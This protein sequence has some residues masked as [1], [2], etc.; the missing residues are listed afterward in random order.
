MDQRYKG[1]KNST[2]KDLLE[3][4]GQPAANKTKAALRAEL[5]EFLIGIGVHL[6]SSG[7]L[8][9]LRKRGTSYIE[10]PQIHPVARF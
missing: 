1:L 9:S 2:L 8:T 3:N 5:M 6:P 4:R 7:T 10:H